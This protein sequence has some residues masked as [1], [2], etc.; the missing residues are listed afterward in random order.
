MKIEMVL[1][2]WHDARFFPGTYSKED[3]VGHNMCLFKSL[4]YMISTDSITT[5]IAS[6]HNNE[7]EYKDI[8]LIPTGS[9]VHWRNLI[10]TC[11]WMPATRRSA[12][13]TR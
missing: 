8:T 13:T 7:D 2:E 9:I 10:L 11:L 1:V 6:E 3:S 12:G 4:G 5:R